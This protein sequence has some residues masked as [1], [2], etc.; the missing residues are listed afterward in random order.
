[1]VES[2]W[3]EDIGQFFLHQDPDTRK[4]T[5][6]LEKIKLKIVNSVP[7]SLTN[8]A[9]IICCQNVHS[10]IALCCWDDLLFVSVYASMSVL[11]LGE[12]KI[13]SKTKS[14]QN[15]KS[16]KQEVQVQQNCLSDILLV[17]SLYKLYRQYRRDKLNTFW[18]CVPDV[19]FSTTTYFFSLIVIQRPFQN[20]KANR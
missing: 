1:M 13:L 16:N 15:S 18:P 3:V 5:R 7:S 14:Q 12:R 9:W 11:E 4:I 6:S 20:P 17:L 10:Y 2:A 8:L 19:C